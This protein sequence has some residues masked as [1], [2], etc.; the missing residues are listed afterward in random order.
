MAMCAHDPGA[1]K[2]DCPKGMTKEQ[3]R[4][5]S[6]K[7]KAGKKKRHKGGAVSKLM[8]LKIS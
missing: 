8:G 2:G 4:E 3:M 5:F 1:A 7:P 6:R